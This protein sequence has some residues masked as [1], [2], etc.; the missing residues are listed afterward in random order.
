ME[1]STFAF[2]KWEDVYPVAI[3]RSWKGTAP[4]HIPRQLFCSKCENAKP[5][6]S[7][8]PM[9][10]S[11]YCCRQRK[12]KQRPGLWLSEM[13]YPT[14]RRGGSRSCFLLQEPKELVTG[15]T[16]KTCPM[17]WLCLCQGETESSVKMRILALRYN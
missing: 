6:C 17:Q 14:A 7:K 15:T 2:W 11:Q 4:T 5:S 3:W 8:L 13:G 16:P 10:G 1:V 9:S 12:S